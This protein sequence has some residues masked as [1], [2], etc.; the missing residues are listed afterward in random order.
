MKEA[1]AAGN[2]N[3][4]YVG[5]S[6]RLSGREVLP[7][8]I[9]SLVD[10]A[11]DG[12]WNVRFAGR[13]RAKLDVEHLTTDPTRLDQAVHAKA[14]QSEVEAEQKKV[15]AEHLVLMLQSS[16][17]RWM[18]SDLQF[19]AGHYEGKGDLSIMSHARGVNG[20]EF[21]LT[22][23]DDSTCFGFTEVWNRIIFEGT[24]YADAHDADIV[25]DWTTAKYSKQFD[26]GTQPAD[27]LPPEYTRAKR[28]PLASSL[29]E[30][31]TCSKKGAH[32]TLRWNGL[33]LRGR[34]IDFTI[35]KRLLQVSV[36]SADSDTLLIVFNTLTGDEVK[37]MRLPSN[38]STLADLL[39]DEE[40]RPDQTELI[41]PTLGA[42]CALPS[43][44]PLR[45]LL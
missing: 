42:S 37:Q 3:V 35:D 17:E 34:W 28:M 36:E 15:E 38:S 43:S 2:D 45:D 24:W 11:G 12:A 44:T 20:K 39:R 30:G 31:T 16:E 18:G 23:R 29:P 1:F 25:F 27:R 22:L 13:G 41:F 10:K 4:V 14:A 32:Q 7:G 40:L 9:G 21:W 6:F 26:D 33:E 8:E 5:P 19:I